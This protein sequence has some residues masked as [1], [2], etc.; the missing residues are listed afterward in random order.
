MA[1]RRPSLGFTLIELLVTLVIVGVLLTA[2][3]LSFGGSAER[4]L[5]NAAERS[6]RLIELACERAILGG[7]DIG[8]APLADGLRFGYYEVDGWRPIEDAAGDEL[9]PRPWGEG[10]A[11]LAARDGQGLALE[12]SAPEEPPYACLS[13]GELT[14]LRLE[15]ARTDVP[16]RWVLTGQ[17]DGRLALERTEDAR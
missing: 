12:E 16:G 7:R 11:V 13:S 15:F 3:T 1:R 8:F 9:R 5:Q 17:L 6:R 14:P 10:V 4:T 2:V